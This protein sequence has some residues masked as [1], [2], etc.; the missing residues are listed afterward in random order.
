MTAPVA[1]SV[2]AEVDQWLSRFDQ[3]LSDCD[4]QAVADSLLEHAL[5][6][7]GAEAVAIWG[8]G[9]DGSLS[10]AGR[11]GFS[12]AEAGRWRHVPPGVTTVARRGF[13]SNLA[14]FAF[15]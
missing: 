14:G 13:R 4:T 9:A 12:T 8:L 15:G 7:L 1:E 2:A 6:P 5:T 3:A 11:A 10:L